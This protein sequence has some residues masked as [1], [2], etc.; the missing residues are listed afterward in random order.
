MLRNLLL[1]IAIACSAGAASAAPA[2]TDAWSRPAVAGGVGGGFMTL[3][4]PGRAADVLVSVQSPAAARVEIHRSA[5]TNGV[6]SMRMLPRLDLPAGGKVTFA[7]GGSHLMFIGLKSSLKVGDTLPATLTFKSGAKVK[8]D[9]K[10]TLS[11]PG[12]TRA[13]HH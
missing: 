10:V 11:P 9:F 13:H 2:V 8:A 6:S 3:S 7:P 4:N 5:M 12:D 1:A